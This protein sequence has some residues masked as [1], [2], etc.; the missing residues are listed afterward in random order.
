MEETINQIHNMIKETFPEAVSVNIFVNSQGIDV[1]P[2]YLTNI[3]G[4]SM[5]NIN[6]EWVKCSK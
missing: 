3:K 5:R 2:V 6:G 1:K 4:H